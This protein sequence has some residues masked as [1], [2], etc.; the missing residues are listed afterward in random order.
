MIPVVPS[1]DDV[2]AETER[3][4]AEH[5]LGEAARIGRLSRIREFVL[6]AQ[7]GLLVPL[8][9]VTGMAAAH[10]ARSLIVVAGLAE[11]VAGAISMGGGSYLASQ[12]EE[13]LYRSEIA[14]EGQEVDEFPERETAELAVVLERE[15]LPREQAETVARGLAA[16]PNVF[17][18]TKVQKEL[19]LSPDAGGAAL[20]DAA[21]V[22][23]TYLAAAIV[24]LWPYFFFSLGLA[25]TISLAC[26][27]VALFAVGVAKGRVTRLSL[28]RSGLQVM[29]VGSV[30]AGVGYAIGHLVTTLSG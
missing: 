21:V 4:I 12:A 6:G 30:S 20:G 3:H 25:L 7:D 26:T 18:R 27:L 1:I 13:Q 23:A 22:G 8:G 9:V 5:S 10:P 28:M 15:G 2:R 29:I 19:G 24:P 16:D 14:A 11:A 17:L